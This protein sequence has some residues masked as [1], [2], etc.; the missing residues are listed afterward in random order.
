MKVVGGCANLFMTTIS[1]IRLSY[2]IFTVFLFEPRNARIHNVVLM[3][4]V[5]T[6]TTHNS[7]IMYNFLARNKLDAIANVDIIRLRVNVKINGW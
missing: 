5:V 7:R 4:C 2:F 3:I 1:I 6:Q